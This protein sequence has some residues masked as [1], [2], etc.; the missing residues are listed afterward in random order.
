MQLGFVALISVQ[1]V[2]FP[3]QETLIG[4]FS[5]PRLPL[6]TMLKGPRIQREG[7]SS[8]ISFRLYYFGP[9]ALIVESLTSG[10]ATLFPMRHQGVRMA[11]DLYK[12]PCIHSPKKVN[13]LLHMSNGQK[14]LLLAMDAKLGESLFDVPIALQG[15][16]LNLRSCDFQCVASLMFPIAVRY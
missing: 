1:V 10:N 13:N 7:F 2:E 5:G 6:L 16:V 12:A 9:T 15:F 8:P 11:H 4:Q 14:S 3:G